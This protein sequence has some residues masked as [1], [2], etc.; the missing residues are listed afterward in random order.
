MQRLRPYGMLRY[1]KGTPPH[2]Q[3]DATASSSASACRLVAR[4]C[5]TR[6]RAPSPRAATATATVAAARGAAA[7]TKWLS[8]SR[9][10]PPHRR[11]PPRPPRRPDLPRPDLPP[12]TAAAPEAGGGR[13]GWL[14]RLGE[15]RAALAAALVAGRGLRA[16]GCG[17]WA[18]VCGLSL[19]RAAAD[20]CLRPRA[21]IGPRASLG[22]LSR[23]SLSGSL[24]PSLSGRLPDRPRHR[25]V[26]ECPPAHL[27]Q[28]VCPRAA[29]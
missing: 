9:G 2:L 23:A 25:I 1:A 3:S 5:S 22:L 15:S 16:V 12:P 7:A 20:L 14:S 24:G 26:E 18:V 28:P 13:L 6:Q 17:L 10:R 4:G 11:Y 27:Q 19:S 8:A 29:H 21:S